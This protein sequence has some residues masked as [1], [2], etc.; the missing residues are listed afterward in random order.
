MYRLQAEDSFDAAHFLAGYEGKC[1][2]RRSTFPSNSGT[3]VQILLRQN[4]AVRIWH[5]LCYRL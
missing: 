3:P 1:K 2:N 4:A 5:V